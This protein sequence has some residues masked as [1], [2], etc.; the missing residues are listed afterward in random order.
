MS[1][2]EYT[3]SSFCVFIE[4]YPTY[5]TV[6]GG[7]HTHVCAALFV[8]E[9]GWARPAASHRGLCSGLWDCLWLCKVTVLEVCRQSVK[10]ALSKEVC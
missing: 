5:K 4:N 6:P 8:I 1:R 10:C 9:E 2:L 3:R 7:R